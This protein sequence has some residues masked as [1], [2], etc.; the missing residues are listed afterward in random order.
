MAIISQ[1]SQVIGRD[2]QQNKSKTGHG[3]ITAELVKSQNVNLFLD[4]SAITGIHDVSED[5]CTYDRAEC[6]ANLLRL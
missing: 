5:E 2:F 4:M 6:N 1:D 3:R